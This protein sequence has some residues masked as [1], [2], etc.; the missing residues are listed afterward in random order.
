MHPSHLHSSPLNQ[1]EM[2][3]Y[4]VLLFLDSF[5]AYDGLLNKFSLL[6]YGFCVIKPCVCDNSF[7]VYKDWFYFKIAQKAFVSSAMF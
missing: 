4:H 3:V 1:C 5:T 7:P 2:C 6:K